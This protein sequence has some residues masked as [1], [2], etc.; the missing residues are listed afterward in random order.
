[1]AFTEAQV[2]EALQT[3][4]S[5]AYTK[6]LGAAKPQWDM[7]A[8]KVP[9]AAA[10]NNYGWMKD[11]PG[12]TEWTGNR[13]LAT[14]DAHGYQIA[15]K[16]WESS[17]KINK[18]NF[19]DNQLGIYSVLAEKYGQ[20]IAVFPDSL[21]FALLKSGFT[22]LCF[23]GQ[24]FFDTDHPMAGSTYSNIVGTGA[25][26]GE[27]W[28]LLDTSQ[29]VKPIIYQERR[30]F[31]F[32]NMQPNSEYTWFNNAYAAGVDGRCNVGF[33]F[34]QTAVGSKA[35]LTA[36]NYEA[37]IQKMAKTKKDNGEPLGVRHTTLVTGY[38]N[39]AAAMKILKTA[40]TTGG[41]TNIYFNDAEHVV[42]PYITA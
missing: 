14:L 16:T 28:F 17:I 25:E 33:G 39:R 41:E 29:V 30:P 23:D 15:N 2:L 35:A 3:A 11:L 40:L 10:A 31:V 8:T 24:Y 12:I 19:D 9:S 13:Q 4:M 21:V 26:T 37:A 36:D 18:D 1:M 38:A 22:S 7:V 6:G 5:A 20:D 42:S 32:Q 34:W 27:P